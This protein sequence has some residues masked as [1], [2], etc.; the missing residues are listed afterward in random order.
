MSK[1]QQLLFSSELQANGY[2]YD[3]IAARL[4]LQ[5]LTYEL[6]T[7]LEMLEL[8]PDGSLSETVGEKALELIERNAEIEP[9]NGGA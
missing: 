3:E 5:S 6:Q 1:N 4:Q 8:L 2:L 9:G 7:N